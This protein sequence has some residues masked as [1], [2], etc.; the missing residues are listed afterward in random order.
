M[1]TYSNP[2]CHVQVAV[3]RYFSESN[4]SMLRSI[5]AVVKGTLIRGTINSIFLASGDTLHHA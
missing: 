4:Q 1:V 2:L 5:S 3:L